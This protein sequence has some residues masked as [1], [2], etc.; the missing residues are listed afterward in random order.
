[1]HPSF[2]VERFQCYARSISSW[3]ALAG[4][5]KEPLL[6]TCLI[7]NSK[8]CS[9]SCND[10]C[11]VQQELRWVGK[12]RRGILLSTWL[13]LQ[14][15][16][17]PLLP[18][19]KNVL[20]LQLEDKI[21][22]AGRRNFVNYRDPWHSESVDQYDYI[23]FL[24]ITN[25]KNGNIFLLSPV[26]SQVLLMS[27]LLDLIQVTFDHRK[28]LKSNPVAMQEMTFLYAI[29]CITDSVTHNKTASAVVVGN[30]SD[31]WGDW[32]FTY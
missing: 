22:K 13:C 16:Q 2:D 11:L 24:L 15:I 4:S 18:E 7:F 10:H 20:N 8:R 25:P 5:G 12:K 26:R 28:K 14:C 31:L 17:L 32:D 9:S 19:A 21:Q 23:Q 3:R 6:I 30:C 27:S 29:L 1:M